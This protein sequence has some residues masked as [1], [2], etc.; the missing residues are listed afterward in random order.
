MPL[1]YDVA[2]SFLSEDEPTAAALNNGLSDGLQ[3]FFYPRQQETLAGTD[4][5]VSMRTPFL[6][7]SR[8]VVVLYRDPWGKT[9]WTRVEQTAIQE[10]CLR[11]GWQKLL[12]V[13]LDKTSD[14]PLWVPDTRVRF[15]YAAFGLE[16]AIGAIKIRVQ[17]NGGTVEPLT[18]L[19]RAELAQRE[20]RYQKERER[21]RSHEGVEIV[22]QNTS[23]LFRAIERLGAE[24]NA[25]GTATIQ[26]VSDAQQCHLRNSRV[27]LLVNLVE[28]HSQP[29]LVLSE[30]NKRLAMLGERL[31]YLNGGPV[32]LRESTF[33]PDMNHA[34][35]CGWIERKQTATFLS[36]DA[37]ADTVLSS[38]VD[39]A[40]K[41][42]RVQLNT[43]APSVRRTRARF[44]TII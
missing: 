26:V 33:L 15:N 20:T 14:P 7:E 5:L 39:L 30:F 31:A 10:G 35:E 28:P 25:S 16:Q 6:D 23:E 34:R 8:L 37:L 27:S 29:T 9:P 44:E 21:L 41:A 18:A 19:K 3:V 11:H 17:E 36:T 1:K 13:M 4:G 42:D 12:F 22:R 38:F 32:K 24:I 2:I 43:P 40:A